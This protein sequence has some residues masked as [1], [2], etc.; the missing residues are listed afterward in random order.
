M[1][2]QPGNHSASQPLSLL[3]REEVRFWL[4][5]MQEHA[6]FIKQGLPCGSTT[7]IREADAFFQEFAA[8]KE[9]AEHSLSERKFQELVSDART[10]VQEFYRFKRDILAQIVSCQL[11]GHSFPLLIDHM[12]REAEYFLRFLRQLTEADST[13]AVM[14][15]TQEIVFWLR[16]MSD[17]TKFIR[18]LL[19]PAERNFIQVAEDFSQEFDSLFL[20]GRDF[21]G[22]MHFQNDSPAFRRF[23]QDVRA[24]VMRLRSFKKAAHDLLLE[25]RLLALITP[26]LADH[27]YREAEHFL[28]L[29][30]ML[31][32]GVLAQLPDNA[33]WVGDIGDW[34]PEDS[35]AR[36]EEV[37]VEAVTAELPVMAISEAT[38]PDIEPVLSKVI[39]PKEVY[40]L[41]SDS[42]KSKT[43]WGAKWPRQ[44]GKSEPEHTTKKNK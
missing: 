36:E 25:C 3:G 23:L 18:H 43:K 37:Q 15:K 11:Y 39:E 13:I 30:S 34:Q 4:G 8:L 27:V 29:L 6:A 33:E 35:V 2:R 26:E 42:T 7:L 21:A 41:P 40:P 32:K 20:Q 44:L 38:E 12:S 28:L 31:E 16:I 10:A 17:H 5:I 24:A 9:R 19:D 1:P 14:S 22:I